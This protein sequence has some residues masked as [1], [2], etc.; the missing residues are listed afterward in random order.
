MPE[1]KR[2]QT[3]NMR[4]RLKNGAAR[5]QPS[6]MRGPGFF[7]WPTNSRLN[8]NS[9]AYP[10]ETVFLDRDGVL[11]EDVHYLTGPGQIRILPGVA[12]VLKALKERFY[13]VVVTNQSGIARG[14][15]TEDDLLDIHAEMI[16][17]LWL[18]G[19]LIDGLYYCPHLPEASI[20]A[21]KMECR[22]RKPG[23]GML[24]QAAGDWG[25][26]L[27]RSFM[28]GDMA[29]DVEAAQAAG[30]KDIIMRD[31][32]T[33]QAGSWGAIR[34]LN[35]AVPL[36]LSTAAGSQGSPGNETAITSIENPI[37]TFQSEVK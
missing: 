2:N 25:I 9:P 32:H 15:L 8:T 36:I 26:D 4:S 12:E 16:S 28:V 27:S 30:V 37:K 22:C 20:P 24:Q 29:T 7:H 3:Q 23:P 34:D 10:R 19:A 33:G 13:L 5:T 21:Y 31:S 14:L 35:E 17:R 11:I 6:V 1:R 18:C